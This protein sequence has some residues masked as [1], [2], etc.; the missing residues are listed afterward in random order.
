M[1]QGSEEIEYHFRSLERTGI[2]T[3]RSPNRLQFYILNIIFRTEQKDLQKDRG[4][5]FKEAVLSAFPKAWDDL[6]GKNRPSDDSIPEGYD[7]RAPESVEEIL[8]IEDILAGV[9]FSGNAGDLDG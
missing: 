5:R 7:Q 3:R 9:T 4:E 8:E 1:I 6:Y 2:L